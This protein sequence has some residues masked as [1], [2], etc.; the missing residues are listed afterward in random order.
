M[1]YELEDEFGDIIGKAR[2]GI[3]LSLSHVANQAGI[4][5]AQLSQL[6]DYTLKP[7]EGQVHKIAEVLG[8]D[9]AKLG[10]IAM[11]RLGAGSRSS[12]YLMRSWML[13][14]FPGTLVGI[15]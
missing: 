9:G 2:R 8:L 10:D 1:A 4:T 13:S 5:D 7:T 14:E 6:E 15:R 11:E 12:G 3:G